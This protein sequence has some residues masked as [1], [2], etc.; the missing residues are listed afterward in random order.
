MNAPKRTIREGIRQTL[1]A[2]RDINSELAQLENAASKHARRTSPGFTRNSAGLNERI[3]G[4]L[5]DIVGFNDWRRPLERTANDLKRAANR[6]YEAVKLLVKAANNCPKYATIPIIVS[7]S[8]PD[9]K[10][11]QKL[12]W[13]VAR[14]EYIGR[15]NTYMMQQSRRVI[16]PETFA[17]EFLKLLVKYASHCKSEA[18]RI[19]AILK[20][21]SRH[22]D[23]L[24]PMLN[25]LRDVE[26][27]TGAPKDDIVAHLLTY[28]YEVS[29]RQEAV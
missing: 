27:F 26:Q 25:L 9:A 18:S 16:A 20:A 1:V 29:G 28:A 3:L 7:G 11:A 15:L 12:I 5:T 2:N 6:I 13:P 19:E 24:G 21:K 23:R 8:L 14:E 17:P 4:D 10:V 22:F